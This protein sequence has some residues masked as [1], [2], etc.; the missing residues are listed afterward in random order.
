MLM[1]LLAVI[2][3]VYVFAGTEPSIVIVVEFPVDPSRV[4]PAGAPDRVYVIGIVPVAVTWKVPPVLDKTPVPAELL[5]EIGT[6]AGVTDRVNV[7]VA[8]DGTALLP[9]MV[10][11]YVP[12]GTVPAVVKRPV[13]MSMLTPEGAPVNE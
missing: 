1:A 8:D 11:V 10:K 6:G 5:I 12:T 13:V 3:K 2:L 9:V 7:W 4:T